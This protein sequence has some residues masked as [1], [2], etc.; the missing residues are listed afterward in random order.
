MTFTLDTNFINQ[1][2]ANVHLLLNDRS[3]LMGLFEEEAGN[4]GELHMFDRFIDNA[5]LTSIIARGDSIVATDGVH[6]RRVAQREFAYK[7]FNIYDMDKA[8]LMIDPASIYTQEAARAHAVAY[9]LMCINALL[10]SAA[11][12]KAG[13]GSTSF[14]S[15]Q[16]VAAGGTGFTVS[17]FNQ[18]LRILEANKVDVESED[19]YLILPAHAVEDLLGDSSNQ[20][21][22]FDFQNDKT[23]GGKSLPNFRG[24]KIIRS[25]LAPQVS[26]GVTGRGI[27]CSSR[28][29][30]VAVWDKF[31]ASM[32]K[33]VNV[34]NQ[35]MQLYT[36]SSFG[37]VRMEEGLVVDIQFTM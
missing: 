25:Q 22:S 20:F 34:A 17:K 32:D 33:L 30:K 15:N 4:P 8:K 2:S 21:T 18:A 28:A 31:K 26:A 29:L 9:D 16:I 5:G 10:G 36:E 27:M 37:A 1:Y 11:T 13:A 14:D 35:P 6:S 19:I 23:L 24:V 12:G 3:K 7:A